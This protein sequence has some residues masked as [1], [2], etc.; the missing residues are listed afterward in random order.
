MFN[1]REFRIKMVNTKKHKEEDSVPEMDER[2]GIAS[3][4]LVTE[5]GKDV[6]KRTVITVGIIILAVKA[7][8]ILGEIAVK[9]TKSADQK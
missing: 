7:V 3:A 4:E 1:N 5:I 2:I 6:L 9:K 8:D